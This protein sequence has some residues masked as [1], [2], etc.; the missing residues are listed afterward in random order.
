MQT[1]L[2]QCRPP[3]KTGRGSPPNTQ[4]T[5]PII[6][7]YAALCCGCCS[8][9]DPV[10]LLI[11]I[12]LLPLLTLHADPKTGQAP[13]VH[14]FSQTTNVVFDDLSPE[15]INAYIESGELSECGNG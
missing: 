3:I 13:L 6:L 8:C 10:L 15:V 7:S 9:A 2:L 14:T 1:L 5:C 12:L 11:L 4:P